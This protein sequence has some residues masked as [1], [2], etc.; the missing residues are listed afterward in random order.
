MEQH[1][2]KLSDGLVRKSGEV[3]PFNAGDAIA[4]TADVF[5]LQGVPLAPSIRARLGKGAKALLDAS[6]P[7]QIV[8]AACVVAVRTGWFGS[9]ESIAQEMVVAG[10][11]QK[12]TRDEYRTAL[13]EVSEGIK[14]E[15]SRVWQIMRDELAREQRAQK[16]GLET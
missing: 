7:P 11:G 8:V 14:R 13:A 1:P 4:A 16:K 10:S 2:E 6:F 5:N 15:K 9:V 3:T 12:A